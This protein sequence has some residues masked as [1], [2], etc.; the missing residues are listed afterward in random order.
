[1][2]GNVKYSLE[3]EDYFRP[4]SLSKHPLPTTVLFRT[5][6]AQMI[7]LSICIETRLTM[8]GEGLENFRFTSV[9][10]LKCTL[11]FCPDIYIIC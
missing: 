3:A 11:L 1:M 4:L 7:T 10:T 8:T 6:L 9:Y 2:K 5:T